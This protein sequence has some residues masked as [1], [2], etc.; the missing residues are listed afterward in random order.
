M[1]AHRRQPMLGRDPDESHRVSTTLEL[2]FDLTFVVAISLCGA[3]F[4]HAVAAGHVGVGLLGFAFGMFGILWAWM[5]YTWFASAFD[6]D[7]WAMRVATLVQMVG[8]LVLGLGQTPFFASIEHGHV[9]NRVI[10]A[11]YV[12]MRISMVYLWLRVAKEAPAYR[13]KGRAYA[14]WI[15]VAQLLWIGLGLAHLSLVW[16]VVGGLVAVTLEFVGLAWVQTRVGGANTPWHPHHISERYGLLVIIA[17]GEVILGTT[18]AVGALVERA[19]WSAD[20]VVVAVAGIALA[21]GVWWCYFAVPWGALLA[22]A[23]TKA[24]G[25]GYGHMPLYAVIAAIGSG[26]HVTAY[27]VEG[28]AHLGAL[29]VTLAVAVPVGLTVVGILVFASY[30]LPVARAFHGVLAGLVL[31]DLVAA[32]VLAA[33]GVPVVWCLGVVVVAPWLAVAAYEVRGHHHLARIFAEHGIT[34]THG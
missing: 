12:V 34:A 10:I 22:A 19:D 24:F 29:G 15:V 8:V 1:V 32:V 25:F 31:V 33:V 3:Q 2:L 20:A 21:V 30:L 16:S 4:A 17:L 18:T 23:P 9:D 11:G 27:L 28:E 14:K 5:N 6:T 26:L 13:E 7:D